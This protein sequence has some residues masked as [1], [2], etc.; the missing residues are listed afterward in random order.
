MKWYSKHGHNEF[1]IWCGYKGYMIKE[2][3]A[4]YYL[5]RSDIMFDFRN[6]NKIEIHSNIAEPWK[7]TLVDTGMNTQTGGRIKRI[8]DY[9]DGETFMMTYGFGARNIRLYTQYGKCCI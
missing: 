7:V 9:V 4:N 1:I 2:Y 6:E 5:H 3:F 8:K